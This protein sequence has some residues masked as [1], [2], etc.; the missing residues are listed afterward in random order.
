[1]RRSLIAALTV[2]CVFVSLPAQGKIDP[3]AVLNNE[4]DDVTL[5]ALNM[6][7][8]ARG[9]GREGM[10]AVG[11]VV[12]NR[13]SDHRFPATIA[14]IILQ[15]LEQGVCQFCWLCDSLPID[16]KNK[17]SWNEAMALAQALLGA[18]PPSDPTFGAVWYRTVNIG[19]PDWGMPIVRTAHIGNHVFYGRPGSRKNIVR[20]S[21]DGLKPIPKP[22][23]QSARFAISMVSS[24]SSAVMASTRQ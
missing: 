17:R 14:G 21:L 7:H 8:E 10:L 3:R 12:L 19:D 11:W 13:L 18:S 5:L 22:E 2:I 6:Y 16:P 15:G 23:R 1:L 24:S 4:V 20:A 9:E